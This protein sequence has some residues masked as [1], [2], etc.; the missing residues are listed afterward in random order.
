MRTAVRPIAVNPPV[1]S[2]FINMQEPFLVQTVEF[3]RAYRQTKTRFRALSLSC[4][5][6]I[7]M[8]ADTG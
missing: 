6:H 2:K 5:T 1:T 4:A 8:H 3:R 7:N